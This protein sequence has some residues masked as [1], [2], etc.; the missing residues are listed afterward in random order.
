MA[1]KPESVPPAYEDAGSLYLTKDV[2]PDGTEVDPAADIAAFLMSSTNGWQP[3]SP[4]LDAE[5]EMVETVAYEYLKKAFFGEDAK[6][7]MKEGIPEAIGATLKGSEVELVNEGGSP[8]D[9]KEKLL[10]YIGAKTIGKYG[11]YGCHDIPGFEGAKPIGVALADWGRKDASKIAFEHIAEYISHGHAGGHHGDG[12]GDHSDHGDAHA[13]E[14]HIDE[15][16]YTHRLEHHDRTGFIWQKL[17][18]PRSYDYKKVLNKDYNEKLRMPMFPFND[19]QREQVVT[20][21]LGLV[22]EPPAEKFVYRPNQ[23]QHALIE[24]QKVLDKYNCAACHVLGTEKW[25]IEYRPGELQIGSSG[26]GFAFADAHFGLDAIA[27]SESTDKQRGTLTATLSGMPTIGGALHGQED[28]HP[29]LYEYDPTDIEEVE[30]FETDSSTDYDHSNLMRSLTL[31][32]G[33]V[34]E[35]EVIQPG[36]D[37]MAFPTALKRRHKPM[38]GD[39]AFRLLPRVLEIERGNGSALPIAKTAWGWLPPPLHAEG[40]KV[41]NQT[42]CTASY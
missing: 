41:S 9:M 7:Y 25:E 20:F 33:T 10:L 17:K 38:G 26:E 39:L 4:Q 42:G 27:A 5:N 1:A 13:E 40:K 23:K 2:A 28:G 18:E 12:H 21:I 34:L 24:G 19:V 15:H 6:R 3:D 29:A 31:W 37:I 14:E 11:C 8:G 30:A 36:Q 22:A 35:G 16:F 32:D